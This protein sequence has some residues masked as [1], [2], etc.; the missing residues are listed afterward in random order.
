MTTFLLPRRS[1][2]AVTPSPQCASFRTVSPHRPGISRADGLLARDE[3]CVQPK[4]EFYESARL[5]SFRRKQMFEKTMFRGLLA[6]ALAATLPGGMA[7]AQVI[8]PKGLAPGTQYQILFVTSGGTQ[9][10]SSNIAVYDTFVTQQADQSTTLAALG[11]TWTAVASTYNENIESGLAANQATSTTNIK[12]YDTH[13]DLLEPNFP[14]LFSDTRF[15]GPSF[16]QFGV[17][18]P[19]MTPWTGSDASGNQW[20]GNENSL[21]EVYPVIGAIGTGNGSWM[22]GESLALGGGPDPYYTTD[23]PLYAIS[24]PVTVPVPEPAALTLLGTALLGLG[25]VYLRRRRAKA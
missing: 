15:T 8:L 5:T 10:G 21:G 13:G 4:S 19:N 6:A 12:I 11:V 14:S 24:S 25:V 2:Q 23:L 7:M 16:D 18:A 17:T 3:G 9:A 1:T 22:D 20:G